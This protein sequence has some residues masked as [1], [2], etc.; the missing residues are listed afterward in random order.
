MLRLLARLCIAMSD[1]HPSYP[2]RLQVEQLVTDDRQKPHTLQAQWRRR[3]R[4]QSVARAGACMALLAAR[5]AGH[6]QAERATGSSRQ[7]RRKQAMCAA[8]LLHLSSRLAALLH[9]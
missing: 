1:G 3:K 7:R 5:L 2:V 6:E 8:L 4:R 9:V